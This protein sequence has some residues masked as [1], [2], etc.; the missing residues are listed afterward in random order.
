[1]FQSL[2]L[3]RALPGVSATAVL[4]SCSEASVAFNFTPC[5]KAV[6]L[7]SRQQKLWLVQALKELYLPECGV[8][9]SDYPFLNREAFLDVSLEIERERQQE[10]AESL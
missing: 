3:V 2:P 6:G 8:W 4:L 5:Y 1:M 10:M 7:M 9:V